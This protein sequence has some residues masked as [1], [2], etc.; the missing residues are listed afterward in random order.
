LKKKVTDV[1][2]NK[3]LLEVKEENIKRNK[4]GG[5]GDLSH[6]ESNKKKV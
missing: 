1:P 3:A 2:S 6:R 5:G 4:N